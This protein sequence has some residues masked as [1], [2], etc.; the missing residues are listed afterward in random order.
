[1]TAERSVALG[2]AGLVILLVACFSSYY[3]FENLSNKSDFVV[4]DLPSQYSEI[5]R[6]PQIIFQR[7][8]S[9]AVV[10]SNQSG[11]GFTTIATSVDKKLTSLFPEILSEKPLISFVIVNLTLTQSTMGVAVIRFES[12]SYNESKVIFSLNRT[13]YYDMYTTSEEYLAQ[14][15]G[16]PTFQ[17]SVFQGGLGAYYYTVTTLFGVTEYDY[18]ITARSGEY[19]GIVQYESTLPLSIFQ[20]N[21]L[22]YA[23][24]SQELPS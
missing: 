5:Q 14:N 16:P 3:Y 15:G 13:L 17:Y 11:P 7:P 4:A 1:M 18:V 10:I 23:V 22:A 6:L 24:L 12:S 9:P 19:L 2:C 21:A 20:V 8:N